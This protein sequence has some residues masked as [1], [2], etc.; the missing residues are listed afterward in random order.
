MLQ[1]AFKCF[2][3]LHAPQLGGSKLPINKLP[4][5]PVTMP[6]LKLL[7]FMHGQDSVVDIEYINMQEFSY[8]EP[9]KVEAVVVASEMDEYRRLATKYDVKSSVRPETTGRYKVE[10]C[11]R[12]KLDDFDDLMGRID[13][14]VTLESQIARAEAKAFAQTQN[15]AEQVSGVVADAQAAVAEGAQAAAQEGLPVVT[16]AVAEAKPGILGSMFKSTKAAQEA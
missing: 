14:A 15:A 13:D 11:F 10:K 8:C 3:I 9:G 1:K 6:E 4:L 2:L 16:E 12:V 5:S 7:A